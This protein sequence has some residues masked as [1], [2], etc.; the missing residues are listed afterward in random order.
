MPVTDAELR[1]A[2][3][4]VLGQRVLDV[5]RRPWDYRS[6]FPIEELTVVAAGEPP[7]R[8]LLKE[9]S[10]AGLAA[11]PVG[12]KPLFLLDTAREAEVYLDV[13]R[14]W[15]VD[16]P[17]CYGAVVDAEAAHA[18]LFLE[19][20]EGEVLWQVGEWQAWEQA[21]RWLADLHGRPPQA[22]SARLLRY[23]GAYFRRWLR[24]AEAFAPPRALDGI[25]A[26]YERVVERVASWPQSL[27]HGEFYPSNILVERRRR[28]FRIRPVDW[29]MAGLGTAL[30]DLAALTSGAWS[31]DDRQRLA[32]V[33]FDASGPRVRRRGWAAFLDALEHCRLH[34]AV[35]WL[36][37]SRD[38]SPPQQHAHD[39]LAEALGLAEKLELG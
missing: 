37:W 6:S 9:L 26:S 2:V 32:R 30:L 33:Y 12:A 18:L 22:R 1:G 16:A 29:E 3:Q 31:E 28:G 4:R 7:R 36:G 5:R 11:G 35:Q 10:A 15:C 17:A 39:W 8:L 25:A 23:D 13:L 34:L 14:P 21:A 19:L 20:I 27:V 38:W 24:R